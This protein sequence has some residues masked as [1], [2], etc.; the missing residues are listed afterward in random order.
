ML[1]GGSVVMGNDLQT[2]VTELSRKFQKAADAGHYPEAAEAADELMRI[3]EQNVTLH[4][5]LVGDLLYQLGVHYYSA[6]RYREA[7]PY[8]ERNLKLEN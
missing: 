4:P 2:Q 7:F 8:L 6:G 3:A 5:N 1:S